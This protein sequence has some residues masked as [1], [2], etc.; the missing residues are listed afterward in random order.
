[1]RLNC[2]NSYLFKNIVAN[3]ENYVNV[4][5]NIIF[6]GV[7][8]GLRD[9]IIQTALVLFEQEG[10][11]GVS[12]K[13]IVKAAGT[14]KG[15]FYHHFSS[16]DELLFVIHDIFITYALEKAEEADQL[17]ETPTRRLQAIIKEFVKVFHL[18][19]SHLSV[20]Y[21]ESIYL[22][23]EYEIIIKEKRDKFKRI[24]INVIQD[25]RDQG[26]FRPEIQVG[27]TAMAILGMVNWIYK[28]YQKNGENTIDQ[29]GDVF[30]DL[31]LHSVLKT[32]SLNSSTYK[33]LLNESPFFLQYINDK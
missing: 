27:I 22:R 26:E 8:I 6:G 7:Y 23:P 5:F 24:I 25:G 21:Q 11:H 32:E 3:I 13:E 2:E 29:I 19:K 16:K 17:Y 20:F 18:Y 4:V 28:W 15:G 9:K 1:M 30:I 33:N 14:S 10:Y 12:I 31:I